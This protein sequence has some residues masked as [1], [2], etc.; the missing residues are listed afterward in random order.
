M[1]F[2]E[3]PF[4]WSSETWACALHAVP[5]GGLAL[6]WRTP[7]LQE[8]AGEAPPSEECFVLLVEDRAWS[9]VSIHRRKI[10][11]LDRSLK[12]APFCSGGEAVV[13]VERQPSAATSM[14][15]HF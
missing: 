11:T 1:V 14:A 9:T 6:G 3:T 7:G 8:D 2:Q 10:Q 12:T 5:A 13:H 4:L 15:A